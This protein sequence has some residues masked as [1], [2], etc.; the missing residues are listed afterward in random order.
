MYVYSTM[1]KLQTFC[2]SV[3]FSRI[4]SCAQEGTPTW[5]SNRRNSAILDKILREKLHKLNSAQETL[6]NMESPKTK[7][8]R[9][10]ARL[11]KLEDKKH[12]FGRTYYSK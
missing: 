12:D 11:E 6:R 1:V 2:E 5:T 3:I 9:Y 8:G 7:W 10:I 4:Q